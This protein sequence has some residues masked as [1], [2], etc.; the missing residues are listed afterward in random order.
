MLRL[1]RA[2]DIRLACPM[3]EAI[4]AVAD[5]FRALS[6]GRA[7]V[8]VRIGVPLELGGLA[9]SMPAALA[10]S[11]YYS[12]KIVSVA[13]GNAGN[14][15]N[16]GNVARGLPTIAATVLLGDA[17]TGAALAL[18]EGASLTALRTGAAGGVAAAS[19][20]RRDASVLALFGTGAQ[21][22]TQL[23]AAAAVRTLGEVR[24]VGRDP[25]RLLAFLAWA[26]AEPSLGGLVL[27]ESAAAEAVAAADIVVTATSSATPV[28]P[29]ASLARGAHITAVGSYKPEMR[30]LDDDTLRGARIVVD[31]RT[32]ALAEAGELA[33]RA[34]RDVVEIGE[35]L[36]GKAA[37]RQDE[38]QRTVF[39]SVGNAIQDLVVAA[40]VYER[41]RELGLGE[42]VRFP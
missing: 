28:F 40:R 25:S 34:E 39:K 1:L 26:R 18:L 11:S 17:R 27:R 37:G 24:V 14:A 23:L 12:V 31:Q 13:P 33:G 32:A 8:P 9:L 38:R 16:A 19:L 7:T 29:G 42:D 36:S 5:G 35:V 4:E 10:G 41:A 3:A 21:A 22:R 15:G 30:E 6:D 2:D 20:S